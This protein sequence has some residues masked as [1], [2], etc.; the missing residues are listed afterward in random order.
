[1]T[2]LALILG[3]Y[4]ESDRLTDIDS[5]YITTNTELIKEFQ[6]RLYRV[7]AV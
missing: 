5:V 3:S 7:T 4:K 2:K 1:M 6:S